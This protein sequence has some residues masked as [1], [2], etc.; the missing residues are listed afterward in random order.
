MVKVMLSGQAQAW[1]S[2]QAEA[3]GGEERV[4]YEDRP[5]PTADEAHRSP[6]RPGVWLR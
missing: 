4:T 5:E 1:A 3:A 2:A 6:A